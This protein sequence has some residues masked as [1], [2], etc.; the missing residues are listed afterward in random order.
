VIGENICVTGR[1][2]RRRSGPPRHRG[3]PDVRIVRSE[4]SPTCSTPRGKLASRRRPRPPRP[5]RDGGH[6]STS[7]WLMESIA[8]A[9]NGLDEVGRLAQLLAQALDVDVDRPLPG[10]RRPRRWRHPSARSA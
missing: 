8:H 1:P 9:A 3:P 7:P 10:P 5:T 6:G 2:D 4:L